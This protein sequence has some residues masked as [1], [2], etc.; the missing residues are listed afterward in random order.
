MH[1]AV[2]PVLLGSGEN[3]L[4][5]INMRE[6]GYEVADVIQGERATHVVVRKI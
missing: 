4:Q 6:L 5:G 1:L 3:L 2:R